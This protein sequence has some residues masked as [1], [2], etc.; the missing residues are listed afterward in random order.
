MSNDSNGNNSE[1]T[2][3]DL[4]INEQLMNESELVEIIRP[5]VGIAKATGKVLLSPKCDELTIRQRIL[6][7]LLG[8]K[9]ASTLR[10]WLVKENA[11][12][13]QISEDL[14]LDGNSVRPNLQK[15]TQLQIVQS[16]NGEY[17]VPNYRI[18][19]VRRA[20]PNY[21]DIPF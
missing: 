8:R 7:Y 16:D 4:I 6:V 13:G 1:S 20:L 17:F 15:L 11:A 5:Y 3:K 2:L 10:I 18:S 21:D 12:P 9:A 14:S 19:D